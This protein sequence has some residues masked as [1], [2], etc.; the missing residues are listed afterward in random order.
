MRICVGCALVTVNIVA[1]LGQ[2][3]AQPYYYPPQPRAY[4]RSD[5]LAHTITIMVLRREVI[6]RHT[7]PLIRKR[8]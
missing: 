7:V 4:Y 1:S 6:T 3:V 5:R 2:A 8:Q